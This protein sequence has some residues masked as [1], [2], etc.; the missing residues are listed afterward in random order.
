MRIRLLV[1][2]A[3][4]ISSGAMTWFLMARL[5]LGAADFNWAY[6]A[7]R[8]IVAHR[9]PYA[10]T[11]PGIIP[12]PLPAALFAVPFSWLPRGAAAG[13]FF[14]TS[15]ALLAF[16]LTRNGFRRLLVFMS[17]PY[18]AALITAQWTP[19]LAASACFQLFLPVTLAKPHIGIPVAGVNLSRRG[20]L[21]SVLVLAA[22]FVISPTWLREWVGQLSS[23]QHFYPILVFPGILLALALLRYRE[24]DAQLLLLASIVPQ[25][26]FYD[27]F[28][29]FLIPKSRRELVYT[30]GISW[31]PGIWRWFHTPRTM[32]E[33]GLWAVLWL[34]LPM[35]MTVLLRKKQ[36]LGPFSD[37]VST[38]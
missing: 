22:S 16:G 7:A 37:S 18:W 19:L 13:A 23:Y 6:D 11:L 1:S 24:R 9:D 5:G 14:G 30:T 26:W 28:I 12:Y 15:S 25:R 20:L 3:I 35:L 32:S 17:Y 36:P 34:F 10:A 29:L 27:Q 4:G 31:I 33:V 2:I 8:D 38:A 21:F